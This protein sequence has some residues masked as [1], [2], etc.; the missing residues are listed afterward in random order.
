MKKLTDL[1]IFATLVFASMPVSAQVTE[2]WSS[3]YQGP[4]LGTDHPAKV[5]FDP[6]GD[7]VVTGSSMSGGFAT[8]DYTTI[9]YSPS[10]DTLWIRRLNGTGGGTDDPE[11]LAVDADGN[12]YITGASWGAGTSYDYLTVKYNSSGDTV[13]TRRYNG[14]RN[15]NDRAHNIVVD[16]AGNVYVSGESEGLVGIHGIFEDFATVKYSAAGDL[17]WVARYNGPAGDYDAPVDLAVDEFGYVYVTGTSD[18]GSSGSGAP[19]F[20]I[21]TIK[22]DSLGILQWVSRYNGPGSGTDEAAAIAVDLLGRVYVTGTV[23]SDLTDSDIITLRYSE[24]GGL[25][26]AEAY[27]GIGNV[28]ESSAI[29]LDGSGGAF[30]AGRTYRGATGFD[31]VTIRYDETGDSVWVR[32]YNGPASGDDN[33]VALAPSGTDG[34]LVTGASSGG[35]TEFDFA[36]LKYSSVGDPEWD[37]RYTNSGAA[38]SSDV[39]SAIARSLSGGI[40]VTGMSALDF[41]TVEYSETTTGVGISGTD[42]PTEFVLHQNYPNPF[43]PTTTIRFELRPSSGHTELLVRLVIVDLL[44][45]EV[46]TLVNEYRSTGTYEVVWNATGMPSGVYFYRMSAGLQGEAPEIVLTRSLMILK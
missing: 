43:N 20:D 41:A 35:L 11:D 10:G 21:A 36:T 38:G 22:Y 9:R 24:T 42:Q 29:L 26:W 25:D 13:W 23:F 40:C 16:P 27:D 4:G 44:G 7:V 2:P 19:Y 28:D 32:T 17:Q 45:Q 46:A 1:L 31:Y 5:A 33:A 39:P 15:G 12:I 8:E 34:V 3:R 37:I 30:I 14:P 18:G 6:S